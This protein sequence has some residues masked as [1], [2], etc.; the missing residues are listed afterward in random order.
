MSALTANRRAL[1][2]IARSS[3]L[4]HSS[5]ATQ[6]VVLSPVGLVEADVEEISIQP[7]FDIFDAPTRLAESNE[8][9]R[10]KYQ[11]SSKSTK[12]P[13]TQAFDSSLPRPGPAPLPPPV[14]FDGPARPRNEALA[15]QRRMRDAGLTPSPQPRRHHGPAAR[16][17]SSS[18]PLVQLFDGP[19][20]I[21][22][23]H[24]Q[25][26][27]EKEQKSSNFIVALGVVG[28]MGCATLARENEKSQSRN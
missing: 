20:R 16:P 12:V 22:R 27:S 26:S 11:T 23:Y 10:G 15:Y 18:E 19:A 1:S 13:S 7:I 2:S 21:T 6:A 28:A 17:F 9:I 8:F 3:R 24:H 25:S 14:I 4:I 5:S